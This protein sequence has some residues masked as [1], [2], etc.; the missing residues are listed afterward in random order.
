[1][2]LTISRSM[3][4]TAVIA[5]NLGLVRAFLVVEKS[6]GELRFLFDVVFL[7]LF[8]MQLGLWRYL[9]TQGRQRRFWLGFMVAGLA[10]STTIVVLL[11]S[12]L[13]LDNWYTG[14]VSDLSYFV[15]PTPVDDIL[16]TEH[17][18]WFLA[19]IYFFPEIV[20]AALGGLIAAG[21]FKAKEPKSPASGP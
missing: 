10:A 13:E 20:V 4:A 18:D 19:M 21:L 14:T 2:R 6:G 7:F 11:E 12:D 8:A 15:L 5:M 17:W 16:S 1:M 9:S 3:A